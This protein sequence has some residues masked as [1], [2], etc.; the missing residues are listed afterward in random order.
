MSATVTV[1]MAFHGAHRWVRESVE[2]ILRQT[3]EDWRLVII[4]DADNEPPWPYL[5][6][7]DDP[8]IVYFDLPVN[9][10][11]YFADAVI[12]EAFEPEYWALQD[13][14]D[15][16][17]P[18]R[19]E[20][21]VPIA[22]E[23]GAAFA[24]TWL[25]E[26][27]PNKP[28]RYDVAGMQADP[29]GNRIHHM[30]GYGSGVISGER[31]RLIGGFHADVRV[32]YDTWMMNALKL[33][34]PWRAIDGPPLQHKIVRPGSL[35]TDPD[36]GMGSPY[37]K[38]VR[39][40]LDDLWRRAWAAQMAGRSISDLIPGDIDPATTAAITEQAERLRQS[41]SHEKENAS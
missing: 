2:S 40:R 4:N 12:F 14:D 32:G 25:Y 23:Y 18:D 8:R 38:G 1:T 31:L 39:A 13:P 17:E 5:V 28:P 6:G 41:Y 36:T 20:L 21:M 24:P 16:S 35:K 29:T 26:H 30:V 27:G 34:G 11:R 9:R 22:Q 19:F 15:H 10:G 3:Y 37:R 33:T 7:I